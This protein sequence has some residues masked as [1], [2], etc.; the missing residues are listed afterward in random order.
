MSRIAFLRDGVKESLSV[1]PRGVPS[2]I[3]LKRWKIARVCK[4]NRNQ[5]KKTQ[6]LKTILS[7]LFINSCL[8]ELFFE[9][10]SLKLNLDFWTIFWSFMPYVLR[11]E[12]FTVIA[13]STPNT[14]MHNYEFFSRLQ[15]FCSGF[16]FHVE[17][18]ELKSWEWQPRPLILVFIDKRM[19]KVCIVKSFDSLQFDLSKASKSG[20]FAS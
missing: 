5:N 10:A 6:I 13:E 19:G 2:H 18:V 14:P 8:P 9:D 20:I 12:G 15:T 16:Y 7:I 1:S 3:W 11:P 17:K 4:L